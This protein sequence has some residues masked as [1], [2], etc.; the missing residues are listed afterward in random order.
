M[1]APKNSQII[2]ATGKVVFDNTQAATQYGDIEYTT[3]KNGK[4][5]AFIRDENGKP[6]VIGQDVPRVIVQGGGGA[7][8]GKPTLPPPAMN[9]VLEAQTALDTASRI[10]ANTQGYIDM[11]SNG[12]LKLGPVANK[13]NATR[14]WSG[15]SNAESQNYTSFKTYL[16]QLRNE[17]LTLAKG[18]Q[19]DGDALRA[20]NTLVENIN[21]GGVVQNQLKTIQ[22]NNA[23]NARLQ[24]NL[25]KSIYNNYKQDA[26]DTS[27]FSTP[28]TTVR[29]AGKPSASRPQPPAGRKSTSDPMGI[30]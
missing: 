12:E 19:T 30:L 14:N 17:I 4:Q 15:F 9:K 20:Y 23:N 24:E 6:Q 26:P 22:A 1:V 11:L 21:D 18:V 13:A 3:L 8:G 2:D 28:P 10:Q 16:N 29:P 25:I 5:V 27:A 7:A